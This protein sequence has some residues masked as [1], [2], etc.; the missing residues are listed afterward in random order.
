ML[1]GTM[2]KQG[3]PTQPVAITFEE[4]QTLTELDGLQKRNP[5]LYTLALVLRVGF[6]LAIVIN[7]LTLWQR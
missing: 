2:R 6:F 4:G 7:A 3:T 1:R 5:T